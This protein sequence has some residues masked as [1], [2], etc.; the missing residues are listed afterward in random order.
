MTFQLLADI[1]YLISISPPVLN[2]D[3]IRLTD[4]TELLG[5]LSE[6]NMEGSQ[7]VGVRLHLKS[8]PT[9]MHLKLE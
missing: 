2:L 5:L 6:A 9:C 4:W 7:T 1:F 3:S 8:A